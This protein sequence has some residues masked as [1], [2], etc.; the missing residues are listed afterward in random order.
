[1]KKLREE[2]HSLL[3][4]N[5]RKYAEEIV[6]RQYKKQPEMWE[7]YGESGRQLSIRD[8]E[9]HIPFLAEAISANQKE[10]FTE[11]VAWVKTLFRGLKFPDSAMIE[12]LVCMQEAFSA[13]L[14]EQMAAV[15]AGFIDSGI[16][17]M[18]LPVGTMES[19]IDES[20]E[21]GKLTKKYNDAL[22]DGN[23]NLAG[24]LVME[25]VNGGVKVKDI[26]LEVFQ[27]SQYEVGRLWLS[28]QISVAKE[29]F[30][31]AATQMIMSQ[32]Y[33]F[34]FST[35]RVGKKFVGACI[36]GELHEIGIRMVA[37]FFEIEGW[38]TYYLGANA[39]ASAI[40]KSVEEN[41]ADIVGLSIAIPY[42]RNLLKETIRDLRRSAIG[43]DLKILIGGVALKHEVD[44]AE[45]NASGWA[46]N[47][48]LAIEKANQLLT[49]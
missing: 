8:A 23:R 5:K 11:Y 26:Y 2:L 20:T 16:E 39:P 27:K 41:N 44:L 49:N 43:K 6:E 15:T 42:H 18:N 1:M 4:H 10:I 45:F 7:K 24:N 38:D 17:Q 35:D 48:Q 13:N 47:A 33:P 19:F 12:N 31:S 30:C 40:L 28:N 9:Y 36:G 3:L 14:T 25:A 37:D 22:L 21:L 32:L 46:P 34:I 29:H